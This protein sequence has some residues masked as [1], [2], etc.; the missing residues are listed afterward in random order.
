MKNAILWDVMPCDS[1][2]NRRFGKSSEEL[3]SSISLNVNDIKPR[4]TTSVASADEDM[5][6]S[7]QNDLH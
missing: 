6:P 4:S 5:L 2:K 3:C 7:V 1:C